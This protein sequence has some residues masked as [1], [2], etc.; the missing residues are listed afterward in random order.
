MVSRHAFKCDTIAEDDDAS[1]CFLSIVL[2]THG[3]V[4]DEEDVV[5]LVTAVMV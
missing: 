1:G 5:S 2:G 4:D 3:G